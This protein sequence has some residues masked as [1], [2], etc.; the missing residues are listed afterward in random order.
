MTDLSADTAPTYEESPELFDGVLS[1][2]IVAFVIDATIIVVLTTF[3]YMFT[4]FLGFLT[5]GLA[6][7][8]FGIMFPVVALFYTG[9]TLSSR[10]SATIGMRTTGLEMRTWDGKPMYFL[11]GVVHALCFWISFVVLTPF[12]VLIGLFNARGRLLHDFILGTYVI[13]SD[14]SLDT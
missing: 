4:F 6:W 8:L 13:N 2:R 7:L 5:F 11:L 10:H 1:K 9:L 14:P 3:A 12:I